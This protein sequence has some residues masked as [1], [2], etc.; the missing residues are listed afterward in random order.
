MGGPRPRG[1]HGL[2]KDFVNNWNFVEVGVVELGFNYYI[3]AGS[4]EMSADDSVWYCLDDS[5]IN[6]KC[7]TDCIFYSGTRENGDIAKFYD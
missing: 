6:A 7:F 4:G 3:P 2:S 1:D 5:Y